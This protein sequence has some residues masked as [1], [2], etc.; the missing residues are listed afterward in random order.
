M[1]FGSRSNIKKITDLE[2]TIENE[3]LKTVPSY[4][5]LGINLDQT[6]NF[7][8][9]LG[10]LVN[11]ISFKLYLFNKIRKFINEKSAIIIYKSMVLPY[12]D[13]CDVVFMFSKASELD[14]LD[15]LHKRG[16]RISLTNGYNFNENELF[17]LCKISS[18]DTRRHVHLRNYMFNN[19]SKYVKGN[20]LVNTRMHD[21]PVFDVPKPNSDVIKKGVIYSGA[22]DW[23][24]LDAEIRNIKDLV[25]FKRTQKYWMLG[26]YLN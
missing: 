24:N 22:L 2:V 21:G 19:K 8:Y 17:N 25:Q 1:T 15:R 4:Q 26:A 23:N 9:H 18:L 5:Y 7:K 3:Q 12:F 20:H 10:L 11:A 6:L 16:M 14:K 13:Y